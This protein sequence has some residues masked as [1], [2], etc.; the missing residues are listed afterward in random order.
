MFVV[1]LFL[2]DVGAN[3]TELETWKGELEK[4][5]RCGAKSSLKSKHNGWK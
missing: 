4:K 1:S 5:C 2:P 3:G